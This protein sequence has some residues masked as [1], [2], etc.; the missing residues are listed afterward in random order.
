VD[1][2]QGV[3]MVQAAPCVVTFGYLRDIDVL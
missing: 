2:R 3:A 1:F